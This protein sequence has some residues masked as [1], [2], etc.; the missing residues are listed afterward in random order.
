MSTAP[1][2][3]SSAPKKRIAK[4][5]EDVDYNRALVALERALIRIQV[6]RKAHQPSIIPMAETRRCDSLMILAIFRADSK[7]AARKIHR[8]AA[9]EQSVPSKGPDRH[10]SIQ[11]CLIRHHVCF[12]KK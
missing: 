3:Q 9:H 11:A 2:E 5:G 4:G 10:V 8:V 7:T 1:T 6:S 12:F